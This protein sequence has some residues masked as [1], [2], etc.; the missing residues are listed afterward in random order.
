MRWYFTMLG[1]N[2]GDG[3]H[4]AIELLKTASVTEEQVREAGHLAHQPVAA[5]SVISAVRGKRPRN[6]GH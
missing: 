4:D 2:D 6:R 3:I 1:R 5:E